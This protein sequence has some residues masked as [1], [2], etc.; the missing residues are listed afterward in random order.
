MK[1]NTKNTVSNI[2]DNAKK[3]LVAFMQ[4]A[5][6]SDPGWRSAEAAAWM[7]GFHED[8]G[9]DGKVFAG[10]IAAMSKAKLINC[11]SN[12][13]PMHDRS[14]SLTDAGRAACGVIEAEQIA[15]AEAIVAY[16]KKYVQSN[17]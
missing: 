2:T 4:V 17:S 14:F 8:A 9:M 16:M 10:T 6:V 3:I 13:V 11:S 1:K 12:K 5:F 7:D 15:T